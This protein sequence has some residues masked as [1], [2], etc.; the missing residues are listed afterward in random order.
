MGGFRKGGFCNN[1]FVLKPDFAI[2][3][4]VSIFNKNPGSPCTNRFLGRHLVGVWIGGVWNGH[5]P[6]SEKF[7]FR[8]GNFQE[9]A[10]NSA[11][12]AIFAKF[13]AP[14]FENSEPEKMQF[15]TPSHSIPPLDSP[16]R[17]LREDNPARQLLRKPPPP[18]LEPPH[19]RIA[20][21][22]FVLLPLFSQFYCN[23]RLH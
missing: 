11:E 8:D 1:R 4:E 13:Q 3:S 9:N 19:S 16:P 18:L 21:S 2:A 17:F 15:H 12:R 14:K 6:E 5:F 10:L 23:F 7:F 22:K 20:I